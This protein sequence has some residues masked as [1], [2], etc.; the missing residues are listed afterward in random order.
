MA[1]P[2]HYTTYLRVMSNNRRLSYVFFLQYRYT[3][4]MTSSQ[5]NHIYV[6]LEVPTC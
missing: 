2:T 5:N 4:F 3:Q 6:S 1:Q